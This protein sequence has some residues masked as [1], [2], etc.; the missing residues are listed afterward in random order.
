MNPQLSPA[1]VPEAS[2]RLHVL[3]PTHD[4]RGVSFPPDYFGA[5]E[6]WL[7]RAA[8]GFTRAGLAFGAWQAPD[9]SVVNDETVSYFVSCSQADAPV[10][11]L[12]LQTLLTVLFEQQ[13]AF[14]ELA[15]VRTLAC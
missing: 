3:F 15:D 5:V 8:R 2:V 1:T 4:P 14:V 9:G 6:S 10:L 11:A 12:K 13:A 7:V